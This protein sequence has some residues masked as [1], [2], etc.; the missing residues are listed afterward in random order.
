MQLPY[1]TAFTVTLRELYCTGR[2]PSIESTA[3][4]ITL[5]EAE[6]SQWRTMK[7]RRFTLFRRH[8]MALKPEY[9]N[10]PFHVGITVFLSRLGHLQWRGFLYEIHVYPVEL[11]RS[12]MGNASMVYA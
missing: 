7:R 6:R 8:S 2:G 4:N 9:V 5:K 12:S 10:P 11:P 3:R 1:M